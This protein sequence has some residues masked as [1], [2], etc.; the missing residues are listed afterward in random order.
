MKPYLH[1]LLYALLAISFVASQ[2]FST[3]DLFVFNNGDIKEELVYDEIQEVKYFKTDNISLQVS[4]NDIQTRYADFAFTIAMYR[5]LFDTTADIYIDFTKY[6]D[7]L[8]STGEAET[9]FNRT[10]Y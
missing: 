6:F 3:S 7:Q 8:R 10:L 2:G 9:S 5:D 1:L 4:P